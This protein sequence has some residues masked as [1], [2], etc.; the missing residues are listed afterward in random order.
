MDDLEV[1][2]FQ[3]MNNKNDVVG[4]ILVDEEGVILA[5]NPKFEM[6]FG[7]NSS[8]LVGQKIEL[9]LPDSL[10]GTHVQLREDYV[11]NDPKQRLMGKD[12]ILYGKHK[13]GDKQ[14]VKIGLKPHKLNGKTYVPASFLG[15]T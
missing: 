15:V 5:C 8:E 6:V 1:L 12:R 11:K 7:Y 14:R 2:I 9:P 13:S 3:Q 4:T 10:H